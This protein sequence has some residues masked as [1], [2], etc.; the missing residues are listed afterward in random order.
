TISLMLHISSILFYFFGS[1]IAQLLIIQIEI[2]NP[3]IPNYLAL[4]GASVVI[5]YIAF[6]F[7]EIMV[8]TVPTMNK[9]LS[10]VTEWLSY[11]SIMAWVGIHSIYT[12]R[13][14]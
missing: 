8:F 10:V 6:F 13:A 7:L 2:K 1:V 3:R 5:S 4:F 11:L 14:K 12:H 9:T